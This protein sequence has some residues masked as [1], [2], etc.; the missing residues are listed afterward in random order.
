MYLGRLVEYGKTEAVFANPR[1]PYTEALLESILTPDPTKDLPEV[2]L[3]KEFPD[4]MA[5]PPGCAFHPRCAQ[6]SEICS[7]QQPALVEVDGRKVEC[8]LYQ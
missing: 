7:Q 1:H 4:P 8:H 6:A 5:P 3:G 2:A